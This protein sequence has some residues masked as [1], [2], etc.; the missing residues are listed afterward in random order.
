MRPMTSTNE[1]LGLC[2]RILEVPAIQHNEKERLYSIIDASL[3]GINNETVTDI[4]K[5]LRER[6]IHETFLLDRDAYEYD[7]E[8]V[9]ARSIIGAGDKSPLQNFR[10]AGWYEDAHNFE[11]SALIQYSPKRILVIG[12]G[13]F[14]TT[15][16]SLMDTFPGSSVVCI[17]K[18]K[19]AC[20]LSEKVA[21]IYGHYLHV[22]HDD[23]LAIKS[24]IAYDCVLVGT[25]VGVRDADKDSVIEHFLKLVAP[26]TTLAFRT[27]AGPGR[28][29]YPTVRL[30]RFENF[31]FRILDNPP[32]KTWTTII[33]TF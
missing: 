12:S 21:K 32:Q 4:V 19:E 29:V 5:G 11:N 1:I 20:E 14:P 9:L 23:A 25:V 17:E 16:I 30:S 2:Q 3:L 6:N 26:R 27:A 15:A 13:P 28:I 31:D 7:R 8:V 18:S 33:L 24:L 10:S 22:I